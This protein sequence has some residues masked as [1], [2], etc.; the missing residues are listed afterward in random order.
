M[1]LPCHST[2]SHD[3]DCSKC[4]PMRAEDLAATSRKISEQIVEHEVVGDNV[5][6][7]YAEYMPVRQEFA[8]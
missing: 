6:I 5:E 1:T 7:F 3:S 2:K 4:V 8:A